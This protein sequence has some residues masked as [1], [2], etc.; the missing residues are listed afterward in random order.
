MNILYVLHFS[1]IFILLTCS[2]PVVSII[3]FSISLDN[4]VDPDQMASSE[5]SQSGSTVFTK[6]DKSSFSRTRVNVLFPTFQALSLLR[7]GGSSVDAVA[8][9]LK[10]LEVIYYPVIK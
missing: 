6:R 1:P 5:A 8:L 2:I 10:F 3:I 7:S 9:A 4:A